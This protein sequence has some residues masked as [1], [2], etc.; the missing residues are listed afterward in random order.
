MD[1]FRNHPL[2]EL[3]RPEVREELTGALAGLDAELPLRAPV[4]IGGK[5]ASPGEEVVSTDPCRPD[6]AVARLCRARQAE[7]AQ[8]LNLALAAG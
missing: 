4:V 5:Q 7:A 2:L 8:A 3:R 1:E 6:R